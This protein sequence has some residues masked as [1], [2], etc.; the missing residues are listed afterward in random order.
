MNTSITSQLGLSKYVTAVEK[1]FC[2]C[3]SESLDM[4]SFKDPLSLKE[5]SISGLCQ[6]CQD[7]IFAPALP[8]DSFQSEET[9]CSSCISQSALA[10]QKDCYRCVDWNCF[11]SSL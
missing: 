8:E 4:Q 2:T 9:P 10:D 5:F 6:S 11:L 7:A 1:G 3:C